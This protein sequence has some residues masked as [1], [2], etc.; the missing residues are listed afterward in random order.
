MLPRVHK[1]RGATLNPDGPVRAPRARGGRRWL[2]QP[3]RAGRRAVAGDP[4]AAGS[5]ADDPRPQRV[6]R[7]PVRPVDQSLS[8][9]R[10]WLRLLLCP[11]QP[12]PSGAVGRAR[13]RD[14]DLRQARRGAAAAAGAGA[15]RLRLQ[16]DLARRQHRPLP[17]AGAA[18]AD[19]AA[20]ARGAGGSPPSGRHRHQVGAGHCATSTCWR[21]WPRDGL[22]RVYVSVTTLERRDRPHPGAARCGA[23]PTA[24]G[25]PRPGA[26][27]GSRPAS[28]WRR[29]SRR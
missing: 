10:A 3:R 28:W 11:A 22:A 12:R 15:A 8:R 4:G 16:V 7:H 18:A 5:G 14:Q 21:R 29:S 9:L 1:G 20:G 27:P 24:G 6:A 13:F 19:H 2:G 26:R 17:A 23:A 25:D